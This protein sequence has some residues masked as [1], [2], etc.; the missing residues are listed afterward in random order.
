MEPATICA[1]DSKMYGSTKHW[2]QYS[3]DCGGGSQHRAAAARHW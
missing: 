2:L 3:K 1:T